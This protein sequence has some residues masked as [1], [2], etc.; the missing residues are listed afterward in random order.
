MLIDWAGADVVRDAERSLESGNVLK[1]DFDPPY[2]RGS[3]LASN[4]ELATSL[5]I[6]TGGLAQNECPC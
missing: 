1:A 5:K 3:V 2:I 4:R 6:L